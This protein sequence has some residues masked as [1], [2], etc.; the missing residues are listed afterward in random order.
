MTSKGDQGTCTIEIPGDCEVF[1]DSE[2]TADT[3]E[4]YRFSLL[5]GVMKALSLAD[6]ACLRV[7]SNGM[8]SVQLMI[9]D[10][11]PEPTFV[12]FLVCADETG[13]GGGWGSSA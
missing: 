4:E 11:S 12:E 13:E 10:E 7:N 3:R 5:Q 6:K 1:D 2:C 8:L 9:R